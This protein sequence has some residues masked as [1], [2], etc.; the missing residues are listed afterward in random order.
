MVV[1]QLF[2]RLRRFFPHEI[3]ALP[4]GIH[5]QFKFDAP[6]LLSVTLAAKAAS[7]KPWALSSLLTSSTIRHVYDQICTWSTRE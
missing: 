4:S 5:I 3:V 7:L 1:A 6:Y 2:G